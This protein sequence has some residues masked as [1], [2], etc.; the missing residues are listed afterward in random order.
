[1]SV[2][3]LHLTLPLPMSVNN[4]PRHPMQQ[5]VAKNR[6]RKKAW[7]AALSQAKPVHDPPEHAV[8]SA[9]FRLRN[10][11]DEDNLKGSLKWVCDT[12]KQ[13]Q[14]GAMRWRQGIA[15]Q[16]GFFVDDNPAHLHIL[17]PSQE[18]DRTD[19][20]LDIVIRWKAREQAA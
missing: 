2:R 1:M 14:T 11:R 8:L 4:W 3:E 17:E 20:G 18:I 19:P 15:D 9:H 6:Y 10:L 5:H 7:A 13:K 16:K 12:L